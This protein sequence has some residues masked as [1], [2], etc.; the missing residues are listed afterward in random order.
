MEISWK[1]INGLDFEF[2]KL[3]DENIPYYKVFTENY[4][5]EMRQDK[6]EIWRIQGKVPVWLQ[7]LEEAL[8]EAIGK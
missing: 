1:S 8:G 2:H 5:F 7:E 4:Y 6:K 3:D